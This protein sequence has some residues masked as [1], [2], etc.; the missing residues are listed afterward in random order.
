M[1]IAVP[2]DYQG[3]AL[4]CA[5]WGDLAERMTVFHDTVTGPAL[6]ERLRD[7]EVICA[8][9]ERTPFPAQLLH[10]LPRLKLLVTTGPRNVSMDLAAAACGVTVCGTA[11]RGAPTA[12]LTM[13]LMLWGMRRL[14]PEVASMR[15]GGWQVGPGRDLDGLRLGLV[16]LGRLGAMVAGMARAFGMEVQAWSANLTDD[17]C[18]EVGVERAKSLESLL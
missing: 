1:R 2:D 7:F 8:M 13:A 3:V 4:D 15:E 11:G 9:R 5:D 17:R 16:G 14:A 6:V 10:A 18:A 12:Q